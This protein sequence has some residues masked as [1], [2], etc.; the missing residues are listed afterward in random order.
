[1]SSRIKY[2][3]VSTSTCLTV[4]LL[5]GSVLGRSASSADDTLKHIGVF[6]DVVAH[7]KSEY[8]E[9]PDMKSV[10]LGALNGLLESID[11][12]ASYLNADQYKEYLKL[13]DLKRADVGLVL[14]KKFGYLG[15]VGALAGSPAAKAGFSTGDMIESIKGISTRDMPLAYASLLLQ[16]DPGTTVEISVVRVRRPE[17]QTVKLTRAALVLPPVEGRMLANQVGYINIDAL[18]PAHVKELAGAIQTLQKEGAQ[19]LLV[20][21]RNCSLGSPEDGIA[22]ANLF[23]DKGRITYMQGQRVPRQNFD[24]DPAKAITTLPVA[25]LTNRGT[26]DGAEI[27][28]AALMDN[29]R[30]ETVGEPTYGD[31]AMRKAITMEDGGAIILSVAKYYTPNG[32]AIQ[33][34]RVVP[35]KQVTDESA[36]IEYDD[37]GEPIPDIVDQQQPEQKRKLEDDPVVKKALEVLGVKA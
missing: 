32:K 13:K 23:L 27:L 17:P 4:L 28:A 34:A 18:S 29:K 9:E 36:Q 5:I 37:N 11:P 31:A 26:A 25:V 6:S 16:G 19:K 21:V 22:A 12:F 35:G 24:A 8:V 1:M 20:D 7:I 30:A 33:D 14:S 10:T 3:V 2:F 15:V